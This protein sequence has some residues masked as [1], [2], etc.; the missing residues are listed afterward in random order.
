MDHKN[1]IYHVG[2]LGMRWGHRKSKPVSTSSSDHVESR[3]LKKKPLHE[4]SNSE[5]AKINNRLQLEKTFKE[6][7]RS[8]ADR[9]KK[10]VE[11]VLSEQGKKILTSIAVAGVALA[12]PYVK[13]I[14]ATAF[15]AAKERIS[16]G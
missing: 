2:V 6:L 14:V 7:D 4:L 13:K 1:S 3:T 15:K 8:K 9:G 16:K 10:I 5:I 11:D 12:T